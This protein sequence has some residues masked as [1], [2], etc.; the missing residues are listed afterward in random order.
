MNRVY[1]IRHG[2]PAAVW[3]EADSDPGLDA[4]GQAQAQ[5]IADALMALAPDERPR[6]VVSSPL[7]RCYETAL[8]LARALGVEIEVDPAV[9]EIP[10]PASLSQADRPGWLREAVGGLW[11]EIEG[12][13]DYD[14][15]RRTVSRAV[16]ARPGGAIFSHFVAINGVLS[17]CRGEDQV[18]VFRPD[19]TSCTQFEVS[20]E[21]LRVQ[22]LGDEAVTK[23]N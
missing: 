18:I 16:T 22:R 10:T 1:L 7:K 13:I 6:F 15:W 21:G 14:V 3:G 8:P 19:H 20:P 17:L 12:D 9:G 2:K 5:A 4:T 23:V 11:S